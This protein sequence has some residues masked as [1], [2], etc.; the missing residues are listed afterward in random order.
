MIQKFK[1]I[2]TKITEVAKNAFKGNKK[3]TSVKIGKNVTTIGAKAFYNCK[4]LSTIKIT[5]SKL[6]KAG[7]KIFKGTARELKV[8]VPNKKVK[9][10][11][12]LFA[13]SGMAKTALIK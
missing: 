7:R 5:S 13:K 11:K 1:I 12:K 10:Y 6:T 2:T 9:S 8:D 3:V 4:K